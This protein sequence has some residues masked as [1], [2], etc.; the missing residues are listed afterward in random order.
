MNSIQTDDAL[1]ARLLDLSPFPIVVSRLPDHVVLAINDATAALFRG[2]KE[3]AVG[4]HVPDYYVN[5]AERDNLA[6]LIRRDGRVRV[7]VELPA[8][9]RAEAAT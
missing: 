6:A 8:R 5:P 4:R 9:Y 2:P 7:I 3:S 1:I